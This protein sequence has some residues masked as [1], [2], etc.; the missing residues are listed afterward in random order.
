MLNRSSLIAY[1]ELRYKD[2]KIQKNLNNLFQSLIYTF[3][4]INY[5]RI[6]KISLFFTKVVITDS[7]IAFYIKEERTTVILF[8]EIDLI[9]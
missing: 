3:P 8:K 1:F 2:K 7:T 5:I 4:D 9:G 6:N